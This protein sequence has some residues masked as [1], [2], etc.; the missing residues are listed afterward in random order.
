MR[1]SIE[2]KVLAVGLRNAA[3]AATEWRTLPILG[4]VKI[5]ATDGEIILSATNLD[6][7]IT[8][9]LPATVSES[10]AL[11]VSFQ[12]LSLLVGRIEAASIRIAA[13]A[14]G[15]DFK[16][17]EVKAILETL[18]AEEFP[19][20]FPQD[21]IEP[22]DCDA[23]DVLAP[24]SKLSCA[25]SD[26][27]SRYTLMGINLRP[28]KAGCA[29]AAT[30]GTRLHAFKGEAVSSE[31]VI[32]ADMFVKAL[33]KIQPSGPIKVLIGNGVSA[34]QSN[35][36]QISGK[37]IEGKFPN[38]KQVIPER[39]DKVFSCGRA[40]LISAIRTCAIFTEKETPGLV[41]TGKGKEIEI[42]LPNRASAMVL[43]TELSGQPK[44]A[45]RFNSR[46]MLDTL[47]V[48]DGDEVRI[49]CNDATS[50]MLI[51]E[52]GFQAVMNP[53]KLT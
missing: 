3:V 9:R 18:P 21:G 6:L 40:A 7:Y 46:Q 26:D 52:A 35:G 32:L 34:V 45:I 10:G 14:G 49:Q 30:N 43:G 47:G 44:F 29:F 22:I 19:P 16:A 1:F 5:E 11:T 4:S 31:D 42:S 37:M 20:P 41:M 8:Q 48:L 36:T 13:V 50:P 53:M 33:L 23:E 17:G 28:D 24:L 25:M 27:T 51:E 2:T 38:W 12:L 39:S 15:M